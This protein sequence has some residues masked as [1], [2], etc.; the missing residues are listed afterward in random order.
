MPLICDEGCDVRIAAGGEVRE[1]LLEWL[2]LS[3]VDL[4]AYEGGLFAADPAGA[5][6]LLLR[7]PTIWSLEDAVAVDGMFPRT[8]RFD[9]ARFDAILQ[10]ARRCVRSEHLARV[11]RAVAKIERQLPVEGL[12][13]A[14]AIAAAGC[15]VVATDEDRCAALAAQQLARF[16]SSAFVA[17]A[18]ER[19]NGR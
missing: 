13:R 17:R 9:P 10:L 19:P 16:A 5:L 18:G 14:S 6:T 3:R 15:V 7:P 11:R 4:A 8:D 2:P 12:P 1:S